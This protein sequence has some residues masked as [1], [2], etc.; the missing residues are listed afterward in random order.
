MRVIGSGSVA[1]RPGG[2]VDREAAV[3]VARKKRAVLGRPALPMDDVSCRQLSI[4]S[5]LPHFME[6]P[7]ATR[8]YSAALLTL[9]CDMNR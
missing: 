6:S 5:L 1:V 8:L 4:P 9:A 3:T 2:F 7:V